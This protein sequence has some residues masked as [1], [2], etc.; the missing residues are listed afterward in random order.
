VTAT[1]IRNR[2]LHCAPAI[3]KACVCCWW[4][5][6]TKTNETKTRKQKRLATRTPQQNRVERGGCE[7][8][9]SRMVKQFLHW[10][11][12][13]SCVIIYINIISQNVDAAFMYFEFSCFEFVIIFASCTFVLSTIV[14]FYLLISPFPPGFVGV[15]L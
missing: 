11:I 8:R 10:C 2:S 15:S 3:S 12:K 9:C 5:H 7:L 6:K 1:P 14:F 4:R 13:Q